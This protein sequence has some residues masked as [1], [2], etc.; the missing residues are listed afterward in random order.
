MILI[1]AQFVCHI[2]EN[3]QRT[4]DGQRKPGNIDKGSQLIAED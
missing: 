2:Q 1:V 4:R 3:H